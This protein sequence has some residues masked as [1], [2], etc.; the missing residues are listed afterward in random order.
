MSLKPTPEARVLLGSRTKR[1]WVAGAEAP[2]RKVRELQEYG[3]RT[4]P[5][6][7]PCCLHFSFFL[8]SSCRVLSAVCFLAF[9]TLSYAAG[10]RKEP[11]GAQPSSW[12]CCLAPELWIG[13]LVTGSA[14][15]NNKDCATRQSL[16][17]QSWRATVLSNH[18]EQFGKKEDALTPAACRSVSPSLKAGRLLL[19]NMRIK[20]GRKIKLGLVIVRILRKA[21]QRRHQAAEKSMQQMTNQQG[22]VS[23]SATDQMPRTC[24]VQ[25]Y[26]P[27]TL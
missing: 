26:K 22:R 24:Q 13:S 7:P 5:H 10:R 23:T 4:G 3:P 20:K 17:D 8:T 11:R 1:L 14:D 21:P 9:L 19:L 15:W 2:G 25:C 6:T 27:G 18:G 16:V 12:P